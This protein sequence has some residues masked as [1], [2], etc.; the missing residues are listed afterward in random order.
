MTIESD[1]LEPPKTF[2]SYSW[3]NPEHKHW[4]KEL[5]TRLRDDGVD[6]TLDQWDVVPGDQLPEFMERA[7]RE[8]SYVVII[9]T[10]N[11]KAKSDKRKGGVGYEG[12]IM[13]AEVLTQGND[14]KFIAALR[15]GSWDAAMPSWL[16]GKYSIDL[17]GDTYSEEQ[18]HD[19]L[20]TLHN[21]REQAPPLGQ[22]PQFQKSIRQEAKKFYPTKERSDAEFEPIKIEGVLVD[23]VG[24]PPNDGTAGSALYAIP[25]KLNRPPTHEWGD[26]FIRTWDHPPQY[27]TR[28]RPRIARVEGDRIILMRTTIEEVKDVHRATLQLV[29]DQVNKEIAEKVRQRRA[30]EAAKKSQEQQRLEDLRRVA[31]E[32][33]F[34]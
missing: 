19:L 21:I 29:V 33:K 11:Y 1:S 10:P 14:R 13:T 7:I 4:T 30:V 17:T 18:Y 8:N 26:S 6:V 16:K 3:D 20:I 24:R 22:A 9:C 25:F 34:D 31:D 5:A 23:E 28:H 32:L 2:I 15:S 12:D 27:T